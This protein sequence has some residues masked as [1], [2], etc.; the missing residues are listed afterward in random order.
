MSIK[1]SAARMICFFVLDHEQGVAFIAQV[2]HHAHEPPD[3]ARM[4]SDAGFVH[5]E[6]CVHERC[7]EACREIDALH[8]AAAERAS[9]T[10]EREIADAD[11][12]KI[13]ESRADFV[14]Q[15]LGSAVIRRNF[16]VR[17]DIER[18]SEIGRAANWGRV[19]CSGAL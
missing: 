12:A 7:A 18:A 9:R 15:H 17:Q 3:V 6:K 16:D 13:I 11:L 14:A 1:L 2:V 4:Q 10:I 8:F 5:D 19:S